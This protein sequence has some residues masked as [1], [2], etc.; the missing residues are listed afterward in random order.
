VAGQV[1][2]PDIAEGAGQLERGLLAS[3]GVTGPERGEVD[4]GDLLDRD[5]LGAQGRGD[6]G[7]HDATPMLGSMNW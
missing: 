6:F 1:G 3:V 7:D 4:V 2:E 5:A